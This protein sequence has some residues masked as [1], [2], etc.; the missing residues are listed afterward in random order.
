MY[1]HDMKRIDWRDFSAL[2]EELPQLQGE[3]A[4][5]LAEGKEDRYALIPIAY[6]ELLMDLYEE[7]YQREPLRF[8]A[9]KEIRIIP[10]GDILLSEEEYEDIKE[11]LLDAL[12]KT[13]KPK[14]LN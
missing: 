13:L 5:I 11:K 9:P 3:D 14:N 4:L 6:Y 8:A 10:Q 7:A 12:E 2:E 1:N